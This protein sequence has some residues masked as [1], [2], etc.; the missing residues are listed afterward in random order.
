MG[1]T[2]NAG[3]QRVGRR[4]LDTVKHGADS[5]DSWIDRERHLRVGPDRVT[6][7]PLSPDASRSDFNM[8]RSLVVSA[9]LVCFLVTLLGCDAN[10]PTVIEA[11]KGPEKPSAAEREMQENP[12]AYRKA[13]TEA[14][15]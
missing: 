11:P 4:H 9:L 12:E 8:I 3:Q 10:G 1:G 7:G 13:M 2:R 15:Q 14:P 5:R 6:F